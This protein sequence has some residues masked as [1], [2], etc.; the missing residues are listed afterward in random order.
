MVSLRPHPYINPVLTENSLLLPQNGQ[1]LTMI[2]LAHSPAKGFL[3]GMMMACC[4][5]NVAAKELDPLNSQEITAALNLSLPQQRLQ[6]QAQPDQ[7]DAPA[8]ETLLIERRPSDKD[9]PGLRLADIYRYDYERNETIHLIVDL[10]RQKILS[11]ERHQ[12][13]QL[14]LTPH[15][16]D[17]ATAIIFNDAEQLSL[18]QTEY[19]RITGRYL[20]NPEQLH[21]KAFTFSADTLPEPL[22]AASL[23]CGLQRCA[24]L[25][26]YTHDSIVFELS[27]IINLSAGIVTQNV[28]Y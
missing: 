4:A 11:N 24:Q 13:M 3:L 22:N 28:S 17:R 9:N 6:Q 8:P 12:F 16:I 26:L 10:D 25:L 1:N 14:P 18:L 21:I 2:K 7:T 23:Q 5:L 19:Q 27:P 15:E 20:L